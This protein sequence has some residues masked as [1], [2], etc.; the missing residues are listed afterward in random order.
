MGRSI[1][2]ESTKGLHVDTWGGKVKPELAVENYNGG[3]GEIKAQV[4]VRQCNVGCRRRILPHEAIV[5]D[6]M[7]VYSQEFDWSK[8]QEA[9]GGVSFSDSIPENGTGAGG[10]ISALCCT[11]N[12]GGHMYTAFYDPKQLFQ[13]KNQ[14]DIKDFFNVKKFPGKRGIHTWANATIEMALVAD[15]VKPNKVYDSNEYS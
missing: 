12:L 10:T 15:G 6:A 1:Y 3:L 13:V 14:K 7:K 2:N 11:A 9:P 4:E 5:L 8:F